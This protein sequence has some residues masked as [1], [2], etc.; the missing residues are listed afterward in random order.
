MVS[1]EARCTKGAGAF[2]TVKQHHVGGP[3]FD[4]CAAGRPAASSVRDG[5]MMYDTTLNKPIWSDGTVWR[6][7]AGT[8]V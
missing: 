1:P 7:A 2:L 4:E 8:A 3:V 5:A 6:D